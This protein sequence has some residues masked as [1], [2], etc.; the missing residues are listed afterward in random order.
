MPSG[1]GSSSPM[2]LTGLLWL[3][4]ASLLGLAIF[5]GI[6]RGTPLPSSLRLIHVHAALVGGVLQ[7]LVGALLMGRAGST[8]GGLGSRVLFLAYNAATI[9][10]LAGF[11][12]H[13]SRLAGVAGLALAVILGLAGRESWRFLRDEQEDAMRRFYTAFTLL[14]LLAGLAIGVALAFH[15]VPTWRGHARLLHIQFTVLAFLTLSFIGLLQRVVPA[16]LERPAHRAGLDLAVL[17]VLPGGTAGLLTGFWLSSVP[18][19]LAAGSLFF[20]GL[21]L[22]TY[23][24]MRTWLQ[25]GQPGGSASDHL[26][27][28][29]G[30]LLLTAVLG[31]AVGINVLGSTPILPY[32]TLHLIAYT[33]VAFIGFMLQGAIGGLSMALPHWLAAQVSSSK[34]RGPYLAHLTGIMNTWRAL[35]FFSLSIGTLGLCVVASLTWTMPLGSPLIHAVAWASV[36]LLATGLAVFCGKTAQVLSVRPGADI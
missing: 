14:S 23:N 7:L 21:V 5:I 24:Q 13:D 1:H 27:A 20:L 3:V 32:G 16:L 29:N 8:A 33:H 11:T 22:H 10:L 26:L 9:G 28:S 2:L 18:I 15:W 31:L 12:L 6:V 17:I 34:K 30:F 19:Q 4:G 35:Q 25:A 36:V